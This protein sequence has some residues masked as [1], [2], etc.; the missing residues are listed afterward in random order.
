MCSY[1][2]ACSFVP[3]LGF[4]DVLDVMCDKDQN[5]GFGGTLRGIT[6]FDSWNTCTYVCV[7]KQLMVR[8]FLV[9]LSEALPTW[10]KCSNLSLTSAIVGSMLRTL[11]SGFCL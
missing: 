8:D 3:T 5:K 9:Q 11:T 6:A 10:M 7:K 1:F 2:R 4:S